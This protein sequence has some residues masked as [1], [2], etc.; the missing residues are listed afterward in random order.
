MIEKTL[1]W[2][3]SFAGYPADIVEP[4]KSVYETLY[5]AYADRFGYRFRFVDSTDLAIATG[6]QPGLWHAELGNLLEPGGAAYVGLIHHDPVIERRQET[7]Y[8]LL[9]FFGRWAGQLQERVVR[10]AG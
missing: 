10:L 7:I 4:S 2:I 9:G 8:R 1:Y 5:G 3:D 6:T